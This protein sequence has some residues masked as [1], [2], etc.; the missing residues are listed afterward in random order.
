MQMP[1]V[2]EQAGRDIKEGRSPVFQLVNTN[3]AASERALARVDEEH[4]LEDLDLTPRDQLMQMVEHSFPVAAMEKYLDESGNRKARPV[5]DAEG[6]VVQDRRAVA[7]RDKVLDDLAS[8]RVPDGPLEYLLN[9]FGPDNLAEVTGR[10]RRVVERDGKRVLENRPGSANTAEAD[11]FMSGKKKMLVFSQAGGTGRSYHADKGAKNQN[12]RVHYLLQP[13]WSAAPAIQGFGRTHRSNQTSKPLYRLATTDVVGQKRFVSSI[14]RRLDQLGAL[15]KGERRSGGQGFFSEKDNLESQY[16][17]DA[18]TRLVMDIIQRKPWAQEQGL[19]PDVLTKQMG[20]SGVV[21]DNGGINVSK[22]PDVPQF[23]NRLLSLKLDMQDKVFNAFDRLME[24]NINAARAAGTLDQGVEQLQADHIGIKNEQVVHTDPDS[25]A[26]TKY[27]ALETKRRNKPRQWDNASAHLKREK[28]A[29][30]G[31][32]ENGRSYLFVPTR[33]RDR[34]PRQC[35]AADRRLGPTTEA[36]VPAWSAN[37]KFEKLEGEEARGLGQGSRRVPE[38]DVKTEHMISGALLPIWDRLPSGFARVMRAKTDKGES[39]LGRLIPTKDLQQTLKNLGATGEKIDIAPDEVFRRV[40]E[41]GDTITL[42]NG[43]KLTRRTVSGEQRMKLFGPN[44]YSERQAMERLGVQ[45]ERI[46]YEG[47]FFVPDSARGRK[48]LEDQIGRTP[49][50]SLGDD[51]E[52]SRAD[53][54][55]TE[56]PFFS[57]LTRAV[58]GMKQEK[59]PAE[60]WAGAIKNLPGVKQ[61]ELDWS[62]VNDWLAE[63]TGPV[64][65]D[66]LLAHLRSNE[67]QVHEV[68]KGGGESEAMA[69]LAQ[70][71]EAMTNEL[72]EWTRRTTWRSSPPTNCCPCSERP[73][74]REPRNRRWLCRRL[75]GKGDWLADYIERWGMIDDR[76]AALDRGEDDTKWSTYTL[77]GGKDYREVLLTLPQRGIEPRRDGDSATGE[78]WRLWDSR[79]NDWLKYA[80]GRLFPSFVSAEKAREFAAKG[81]GEFYKSSHWDEPN[82][83]AHV[84]FDDRTGP[85]GEKILHVAEIQSDWH[86]AGRKQRL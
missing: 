3:E 6:N 45:F 69:E 36:L 85:N 24:D 55:Q 20:L 12:R 68:M 47:M 70:E 4:T 77:P 28:G 10:G 1:T 58:E 40:R 16:A 72:R 56:P 41:N 31:Q 81:A 22:I 25:G 38:F 76:E 84:R 80:D 27:V 11:A 75:G 44:P 35:R 73:L 54:E 39:Y 30:V 9:Q 29:F 66:A 86:Q 59:A 83:L 60:Q 8:I 53:P 32:G 23:L 21:D 52:L 2:L 48:F 78:N 5:L 7:I 42:A 57:A 50:V 17:D 15:T 51:A 43:W 37:Q 14:A 49:I 13:G 79:K 65:K 67:V 19:T 64:T 61:E 74:R 62:G 82:I 18:V 46:G 71:R 26:E 34:R 63:Q 33:E